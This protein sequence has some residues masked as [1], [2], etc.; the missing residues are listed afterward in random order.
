MFSLV[1]YVNYGSE[2]GQHDLFNDWNDFERRWFAPFR[3]SFRTDI[4]DA[5][6]HYRL[7]AELPGFKK[8]EIKVE[9]NGSYL[10]IYAEHQ[11]E[12]KSEE[13]NEKFI[14][15]ERSFGSFMRGFNISNV[16]VDNI[17]VSYVDGMLKLD[18]PKKKV[19]NSGNR[20]IEIN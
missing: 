18:L 17:T 9:V 5:G 1:P 3:G 20:Q 7:E 11:Q 16:D 13:Q 2:V 8:E 15:C 4:V 19:E 6:D 10:N 14:H 12:K